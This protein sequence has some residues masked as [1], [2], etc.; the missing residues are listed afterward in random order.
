MKRDL[1]E[2][3]IRNAFAQEP[4]ACHDALMNAAFS[5]KE[6]KTVKK[7]SFRVALVVA[8][9]IV[10][11]MTVAVAAGNLL[12]FVDFFGGQYGTTVPET[13]QRVM[14]EEWNKHEF[15]LG[16]VVFT[17]QE[18]FCDGHIAMA[19]T[20]ISMQ[21]G[22]DALIC[23]EPYDAV[24]ATGENGEQA[25]K[26]LGV[27][28]GMTWIEA[29]KKLNRKLYAVRAILEVPAEIDSG[30]AMEDFLY[31]ED[32]SVTYFSMPESNGKA[33]GETVD[34]QMF[35]RV[36]EID[37][38]AETE[39][40]VLKER[41]PL[42]IFLEAPIEELVYACNGDFIA[43]GYKLE[44]IKAELSG[45]GLYLYS[46]FIAPDGVTEADVYER[47]FPLWLDLEE[48]ALPSGINLSA[49][50]DTQNL[51][52]ITYMQM[53]SVNAIPEKMIMQVPDTPFAT[54]DEINPGYQRVILSK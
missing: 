32:G 27:E 38:D 35:L 29:A 12:G 45:A 10:A 46:T 51:P 37:L 9:I 5:V 6:E 14:N 33:T 23:A 42:S 54:A 43:D 15:A 11:T 4:A 44:S 49:S 20:V 3:N 25:A 34:M 17:T 52:K 1:D 53:L 40:T 41:K 36:A 30:C 2:L 26:R 48:K 47:D 28:P 19:S 50:V 21:D 16:E 8:L 24:G 39:T 18:L 22:S 31:N 13:A 7:A